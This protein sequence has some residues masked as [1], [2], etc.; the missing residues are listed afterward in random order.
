MAAVC[1]AAMAAGVPLAQAESNWLEPEE[2]TFAGYTGP[3]SYDLLLRAA[4][5]EDDHYRECQLL[6]LPTFGQD[7]VVYIVDRGASL[8]VVSRTMKE[9]PWGQIQRDLVRTS[10]DPSRQ[11]AIALARAF[12]AVRSAADTKTAPIDRA[13]ANTV[14][15]ACREVL[16]GTRYTAEPTRGNDG[17]GYHAGH[18]ISG[19]FLAGQTWSP[20]PG[21]IAREFVD[22]EEALAAYA[23]AE[24]SKRDTLKVALLKRATL[25]LRRAQASTATADGGA[26]SRDTLH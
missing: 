25:L 23:T 3:W 13:T 14:M 15:D 10:N 16:L 2:G 9:E 8:T 22:M 24:P 26:A 7:G 11:R 5:L 4:M 21:T 19:T 17:V 1:A 12:D 20:K 6:R 18:W